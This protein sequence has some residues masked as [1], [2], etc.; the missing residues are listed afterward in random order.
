M[1][2]IK[3]SETD[4]SFWHENLIYGKGI[5]LTKNECIQPMKP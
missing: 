1:N 5:S 4:Y 3:V 2:W